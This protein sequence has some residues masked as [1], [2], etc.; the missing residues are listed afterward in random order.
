MTHASEISTRGRAWSLPPAAVLILVLAMS[1]DAQAQTDAKPTPARPNFL[2]LF[3]DDLTHRAIRVSGNPDVETPRIDRLAA[4]G[5]RYTH[6]HIQGGLNGAVCIASRA[7]LMTGRG[8]WRCGPGGNGTRPDGSLYPLWG[9][10]L[11]DAGYRT[12]AVGK[13]HNGKVA[14]ANSFHTH[15]ETI[16]GGMLASTSTEGAAY[17]RPAP[18]NPWRPDDPSWKGH[19]RTVDGKVDHSSERWADAAIG[20][21]REAA[22]LDR[23]FFLSVAF[24]APHDPRQAPRA[25]LDRYREDRLTLP[26]NLAPKHSFDLGEFST[27]DEL[28]TPYPRTEEAV[29]MHLREYYAI[30]SHLDTQIGRI[31]DELDR[32]G[33]TDETVVIFA[34]DN[35]LA[36]GEHGLIGK[37]SLYDHSI[38]VPLILAGPG[39]PRGATN[40]RLVTIASL[41][42]TTCRLAGIPTPESVQFPP[43]DL[44]AASVGGKDSDEAIHAAYMNKQRMIRTHQWKLIE[45]PVASRIQLFAIRDDPWEMNDLAGDPSK[46]LLIDWLHA[47]LKEWCRSS[48]DPMSSDELDATLAEHRRVLGRPMR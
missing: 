36:V 9:R 41:F 44:A 18:G 15:S 7:M 34:G 26:K 32:L 27:R 31:L 24:H 23:P 22:G 6:A 45:S 2:F 38:R 12:Y 19:W 11:G 25:D 4:R 20:H 29:R 47:R 33:L 40:D 13:W 48:D 5:L 1:L 46:Q 17:H 10:T 21:L 43:L 37:Q 8:L 3:A 14:L 16:L 30:I 28:L 39:I 42:S 35:G